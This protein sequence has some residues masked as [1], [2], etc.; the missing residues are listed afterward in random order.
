MTINIKTLV[1]AYATRVN[2]QDFNIAEDINNLQTA[3]EALANMTYSQAAFANV[4]TLAAAKTLTDDSAVINMLNPN[5]A[6][7][8]VNLP[9]VAVTN[10]PFLIGNTNGSNYKLTV[11][12]A[13]GTT[14]RVVPAGKLYLFFSDGSQWVYAGSDIYKTVSPSQI[15]ASQNNYNP[16]GAYE[17][18]ILRINSDAAWDITGLAGGSAGRIKIVHNV[19]GFAIT[20]KDESGSSTDVNRFALNTDL[21]L[22][23]DQSVMFL[24]DAVSERWRM[25]G[26]SGG[27]SSAAGPSLL[28]VQVFS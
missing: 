25:V 20:F 9:A 28:Q 24:Y 13:G 16:T 3:L 19:G 21:A 8:D 22:A 18:D 4:E 26:G 14:I 1:D 11:K 15:T 2:N 7:R 6:D 17:A 10:H 5:A 23:A 12:N 27:G